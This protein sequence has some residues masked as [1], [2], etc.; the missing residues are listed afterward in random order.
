MIEAL[1]NGALALRAERAP[2]SEDSYG[3]TRTREP[4]R[5]S[6][7]GPEPSR[8]ADIDDDIPF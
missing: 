6:G 7:G 5:A 3:S 4:A 1:A 8:A 2:P